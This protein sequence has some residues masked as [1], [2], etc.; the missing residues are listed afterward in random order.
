MF[1][2][3]INEKKCSGCGKCGEVCPKGPKIWKLENDVAVIIDLRYCI[4]CK[5]CAALCPEGII[6]IKDR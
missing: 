3:T 4:N 5:N 1:E 6:K 2:I